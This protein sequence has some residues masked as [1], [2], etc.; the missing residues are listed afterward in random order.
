MQELKDLDLAE[1]F[2]TLHRWPFSTLLGVWLALFAVIVA[3]SAYFMW[4]PQY[5]NM[6]TLSAEIT[7]GLGK[8]E[9][10][11]ALLAKQTEIEKQLTEHRRLLPQLQSALPQG[12][13]VPDLLRNIYLEIERNQMSLLSFEPLPTNDTEVL[14]MVPVK[15]SAMGAGAPISRLP[16]IVSALTRK[17]MLN[18]F[19]MVRNAESGA[20]KLDGSLVAF[21]QLP[22]KVNPANQSLSNAAL[23]PGQSLTGGL[24]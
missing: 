1:A 7:S 11:S 4:F 5:Q 8:L 2:R 10:D 22:A 3:A 12:K 23:T 19:E 14:S 18:E 13:E 9:R 20:W 24:R 6:K 15:L 21:T 17:V 16:L